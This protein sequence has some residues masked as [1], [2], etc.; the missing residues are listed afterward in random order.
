MGHRQDGCL[1]F[2]GWLGEEHG[3]DDD[4]KD[5]RDVNQNEEK[6]SEEEVMRTYQ[7]WL[8]SVDCREVMKRCAEEERIPRHL[9]RPPWYPN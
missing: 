2:E 4:D 3:Q 5:K 6:R 9:W 1:A 7:D 8:D